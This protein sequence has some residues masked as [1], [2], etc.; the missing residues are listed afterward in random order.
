MGYF[1]LFGLPEGATMMDLF[2]LKLKYM[3]V[4]SRREEQPDGI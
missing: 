1:M 3:V 4:I 2:I